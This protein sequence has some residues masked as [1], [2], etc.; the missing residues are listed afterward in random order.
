MKNTKSIIISIAIHLAIF[1]LSF[2]I[3]IGQKQKNDQPLSYTYTIQTHVARKTQLRDNL[4]MA[5]RVF[6]PQ[7]HDPQNPPVDITQQQDDFEQPLTEREVRPIKSYEK[8]GTERLIPKKTKTTPPK[9]IATASE[10]LAAVKPQTP[11]AN[12]T[13]MPNK[14]TKPPKQ[15]KTPTKSSPQ[16]TLTSSQRNTTKTA[17]STQTGKSE[18]SQNSASISR[19]TAQNNA[20]IRRPRLRKKFKIN[21]PQAA[22]RLRLSGS[23]MLKIQILKNGRVGEIEVLKGSGM[24]ILDKAAIESVKTWLFYPATKNG[25]PVN[26]RIK[27]PITFKL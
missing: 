13:K 25:T 5:P 17:Q 2:T 10:N 20:K 12:T 23:L 14:P 4:R 27:V 11:R 26:S 21:Y 1:S 3:F 18:K 19:N 6:E 24:R 8:F 16:K 9:N 7:I 15:N 22:K